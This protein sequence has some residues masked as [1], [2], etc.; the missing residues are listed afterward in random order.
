MRRRRPGLCF[1]ITA[2]RSN[3]VTEHCRTHFPN[4]DVRTGNGF[5][6]GSCYPEAS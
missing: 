5:F 6:R 3:D 4:A 1:E 2:E